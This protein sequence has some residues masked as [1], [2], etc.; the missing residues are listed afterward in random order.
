MYGLES[1]HQVSDV[2]GKRKELVLRGDARF[3]LDICIR[4]RAPWFFVV[5]VM[6]SPKHALARFSSMRMS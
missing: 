2:A 1:W 5:S 4:I 3:G 6:S